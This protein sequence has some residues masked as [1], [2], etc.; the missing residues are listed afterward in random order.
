MAEKLILV[1]ETTTRYSHLKDAR[2]VAT[3]IERLQAKG[4][5]PI[6]RIAYVQEGEPSSLEESIDVLT[7]ADMVKEG[8]DHG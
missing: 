4:L 1:E 7:E 5:N 3:A 2:D 6:V 8:I